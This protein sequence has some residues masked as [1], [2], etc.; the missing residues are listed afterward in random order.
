MAWYVMHCSSLMKAVS[1]SE[2]FIP[3]VKRLESSSWSQYYMFYV[4]KTI[5]N[6]SN[7][8]LDRCFPEISG[9]SYGDKFADLAGP[10]EFM[11]LPSGVFWWLINIWPE[12]LVFRQGDSCTIEPLHA[13]SFY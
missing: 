1:P 10:D 8:Q 5:L 2:G 11:W 6:S 7:Y 3:F 9:A 12:Y 13:Q 4:W